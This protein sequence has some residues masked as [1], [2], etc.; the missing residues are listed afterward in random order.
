[1]RGPGKQT[2]LTSFSAK[3]TI[4]R[5]GGKVWRQILSRNSTGRL[6]NNG[7][8]EWKSSWLGS[9]SSFFRRGRVYS[10]CAESSNLSSGVEA[11]TAV[12]YMRGIILGWRWTYPFFSCPSLANH[13]VKGADRPCIG[14]K[15]IYRLNLEKISQN[16]QLEL[17][18]FKGASSH[19]TDCKQSRENSRFTSC[20]LKYS[21]IFHLKPSI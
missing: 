10:A 12:S 2:F 16:G 3:V 19:V 21:V 8:S 18:N 5:V 14:L 1:V 4:H 6:E 11:E 15:D 17:A 20:S 9:G 13:S 7:K